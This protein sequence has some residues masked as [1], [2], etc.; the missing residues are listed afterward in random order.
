[1]ECVEYALLR[2]REVETDFWNLMKFPSQ[3]GEFT[4]YGNG[5]RSKAHSGN[6][7]RLSSA[8]I[9]CG[10]LTVRTTNLAVGRTS[11]KVARKVFSPCAS[12]H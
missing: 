10:A 11:K 6:V 12:G 9:G 3:F 8:R 7:L 5:I 1:M 2:T 4:L